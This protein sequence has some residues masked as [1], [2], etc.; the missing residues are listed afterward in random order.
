MTHLVEHHTEII[1][2][3]EVIVT[4]YRRSKRST[5]RPFQRSISGHTKNYAPADTGAKKSSEE[6]KTL[7]SGL[8]FVMILNNLSRTVTHATNTDVNNKRSQ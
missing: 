4:S 5:Y 8:I 7:Y 3:T 2:V 6:Q 1:V